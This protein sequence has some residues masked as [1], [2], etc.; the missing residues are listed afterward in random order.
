[1]ISKELLCEV[2]NVKNRFKC[3]IL[4]IK[5]NDNF[6]F[7]KLNRIKNPTKRINIHQLA[8]KCKEW[9]WDKFQ[10]DIL[11]IKDGVKLD[12]NH[13]RRNVYLQ[14]N[15]KTIHF[16]GSHSNDIPFHNDNIA[17][18]KACQWILDEEIKILIKSLYY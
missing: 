6:L 2:L 12:A 18:V 15:G 16:F 14:K 9:A 7:Y 5:I 4:S 1:M 11:I 13:W 3:D 10:I 17:M 8:D